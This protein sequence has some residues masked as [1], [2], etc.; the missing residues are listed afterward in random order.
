MPVRVLEAVAVRLVD[1][2]AVRDDDGVGLLEGDGVFELV[3]LAEVVPVRVG[4]TLGTAVPLGD[5]E[6][7]GVGVMLDVAGGVRA[8]DALSCT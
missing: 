3:A 6:G 4:V 7:S 2:V 8:D 1:G 5:I